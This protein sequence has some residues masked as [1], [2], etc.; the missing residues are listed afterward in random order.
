MKGL[1]LPAIPSQ[2]PVLSRLTIITVKTNDFLKLYDE[3]TLFETPPTKNQ[4]ENF[5]KGL[6]MTP[7][8]VTFPI[9]I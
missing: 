3:L 6:Q 4:T 5:K 9:S 7:N 1:T 8:V 2:R